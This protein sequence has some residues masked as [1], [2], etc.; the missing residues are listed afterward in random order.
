MKNGLYQQSNVNNGDYFLIHKRNVVVFPYDN[1]SPSSEDEVDQI[2]PWSDYIELRSEKETLPPLTP[3]TGI[4]SEQCVELIEKVDALGFSNATAMFNLTANEIRLLKDQIVNIDAS[5]VRIYS[6]DD[7][8]RVS[9]FDIQEFGVAYRFIRKITSQIRY[10]DTTGSIY[11]QFSFTLLA[12]T[13]EK[14]GV[15][16]LDFRIGDNGVLTATQITK[17]N[18]KV[19]YIR[20]QNII[21]PINLFYS[22]KTDCHISFVFHPKS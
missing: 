5:H 17:K 3:V 1:F 9:L 6:H 16:D 19:F 15:D 13:F 12:S 4:D 22:P 10:F 8:I 7:D 18:A 11:E 2:D 20:D 14:L 21:E